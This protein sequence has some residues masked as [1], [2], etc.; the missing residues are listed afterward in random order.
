MGRWLNRLRQAEKFPETPGHGTDKTDKTPSDRLLS[1]L[2]VRHRAVFTKKMSDENALEPPV[3]AEPFAPAGL[4]DQ[5]AA[6]E[7]RAGI[8]EYDE[9]LPRAEAERLAREQT[10]HLLH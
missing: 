7:E 10:R 4:E 8:L 6:F 9:G 1:V 2:S 3:I 5:I